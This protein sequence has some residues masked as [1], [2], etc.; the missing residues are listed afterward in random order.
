MKKWIR[1]ISLGVALLLVIVLGASL[2]SFYMLR[3]TPDWYQP[4][5]LSA[6]EREAAANRVDQRLLDTV[7]WASEMQARQ[8]RQRAE[9]T[10]AAETANANSTNGLPASR[11]ATEPSNL[12]TISFSEAELN[13]FFQ[14][15]SQAN[16]W[17]SILNNYMT[18]PVLVIHE[19]RII[20]AGKLKEIDAVA[21]MHFEPSIDANGKFHLKMARML[22]GRLPLPT[23]LFGKYR[24]RITA[25]LQ[26][27]LPL[28]QQQANIDASGANSQ[29]VYAGMSKLLID[30][31]NDRPAEPT[32]FLKTTGSANLP[33]RLHEVSVQDKTLTLSVEPL[34]SAERADLL[35][36]IREPFDSQTARRD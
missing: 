6:E 4:P 27:R 10:A 8:T 20:I 25:G 36:R 5:T 12:K 17:D 31:L 33:V 35:D 1:R 14:K 9:S 23:S 29:A 32:I 24:D 22:G 3:G 18:D 11:P 34:T 19:G 28:W 21:S 26:R 30:A 15:W 13:A 7:S 2:W 16:K